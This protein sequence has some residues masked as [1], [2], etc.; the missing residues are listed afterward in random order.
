M[1][2]AAIQSDI[3]WR[4]SS[5][6]RMNFESIIESLSDV[7]LVVLP[8]MFTTGFCTDPRGTAEKADTETLQWMKELS[9]KGGF[10]MA[11][12]VAVEQDGKYYNRLYFVKP[13]GNWEKYDK[14]HLFTF[15]GEH[16]N[17]TAGDERVVVEYN[18]WKILLQ[19]CY[20]LRFPIYSRNK[21]DYDIAIYVASW[22]SVRI[23]P[24]ITLLKARAIENLSY[25]IGVNRVG[26][27]PNCQYCGGS[28]IHD[29]K[30]VPMC[31]EALD[32]EEVLVAEFKKDELDN[33]R[34]IFPALDDED[35]FILESV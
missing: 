4:E 33:F 18:G 21:K 7:D 5:A 16:N 14:H 31:D 13:D 24:W 22:P 11:G 6:N 32:K 3:I 19:I 28:M 9:K 27:D 29:F 12:S 2:I 15:A 30:G 35:K 10:A 17:Y 20:D 26:N 23:D 1:R 34:A 8:E 25:V